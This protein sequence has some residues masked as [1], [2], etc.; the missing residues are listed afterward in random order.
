MDN[1][2][3]QHAAWAIDTVVRSATPLGS[4]G[5]YVIALRAATGNF[6]SIWYVSSNGLIVGVDSCGA[7]VD[8]TLFLKRVSG[9]DYLYGPN[10]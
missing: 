5:G 7:T 3:G 9:L 2:L 4:Q 1:T 10:P 8:K 6:G